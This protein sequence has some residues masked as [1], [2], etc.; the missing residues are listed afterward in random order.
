M[1]LKAYGTFIVGWR[2]NYGKERNYT[3]LF[4]VFPVC[5]NGNA[6]GVAS[7]S[8]RNSRKP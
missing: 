3:E 4:F 2:L 6:Q 1:D 5:L 8:G 7:L